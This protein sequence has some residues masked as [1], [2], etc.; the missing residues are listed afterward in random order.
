MEAILFYS[1][2]NFHFLERV[3][4]LKFAVSLSPVVRIR[5]GKLITLKFQLG[6]IACRNV[7]LHCFT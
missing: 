2:Q 5:Q 3:L 7:L 4:Q 1:L 6:Y